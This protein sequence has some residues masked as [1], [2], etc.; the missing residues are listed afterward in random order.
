MTVPIHE[1]AK[2]FSRV[3]RT[4]TYGLDPEVVIYDIA[5]HRWTGPPVTIGM[6]SDLH[7]ISPWTPMRAL[8]N[9]VLRMNRMQLDLVFVLG[10]F[11]AARSTPGTRM[12]P[13][14]VAGTLAD[15]EAAHGVYTV[16][17]NHDWSDDD[18]ACSNGFIESSVAR[19]LRDVNLNPLMN[20]SRCLD[21]A[22]HALWLVGM[23]SQRGHLPPNGGGARHDP[24]RAFAG[25]PQGA[26][27]ILLAHEPDYFVCGD[28]R[29]LLQVSGH[30]HGG[31]ANFWGWRPF[32]PSE[33]ADRYAYG[34]VVEDGRHL[35]VSGGLGYTHIPL[36]IMQPPEI[37]L[38]RLT[39]GV[40]GQAVIERSD[41]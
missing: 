9:I 13:T 26:A 23:D 22:G 4:I 5:S 35:I 37:T 27:S 28:D 30:T 29:P 14:E 24:D 31:Q 17:G 16:M 38:I 34:H 18:T 1:H 15:L 12:S 41:L 36:R 19:A 8:R 25:V 39:S 2:R 33:Y 7:M 3:K 11:I 32:T 6:I 21:I 10:D 40:A 20:E